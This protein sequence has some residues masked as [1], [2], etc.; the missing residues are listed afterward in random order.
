MPPLPGLPCFSAATSPSAAEPC[1]LPFLECFPAPAS[2]RLDNMSSVRGRRKPL[3]S[4]LQG[5]SVQSSAC[6]QSDRTPPR[7]HC[8]S[9]GVGPLPPWPLQLSA[10]GF[11]YPSSSPQDCALLGA[12]VRYC[13]HFTSPRVCKPH[14]CALAPFSCSVNGAGSLFLCPVTRVWSPEPF[15]SLHLSCAPLLPVTLVLAALGTHLCCDRHFLLHSKLI[16]SL[17]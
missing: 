3:Q 13:W 9:T 8:H 12:T 1:R 10:A 2:G 16:N 17:A 6:S 14:L 4:C 11:S 15:D 7:Q 5:F